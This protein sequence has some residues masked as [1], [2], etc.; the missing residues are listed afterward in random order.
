MSLITN[1]EWEL[2]GEPCPQ[3]GNYFLKMLRGRKFTALESAYQLA[4]WQ[5]Y[6]RRIT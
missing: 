6:Q 5:E 4:N 1:P 2:H 3:C